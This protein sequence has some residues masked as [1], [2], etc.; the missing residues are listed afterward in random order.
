ME[1]VVSILS[2][3]SAFAPGMYGSVCM[4]AC[5]CAAKG[6]RALGG[7]FPGS[8]R[9]SKCIEKNNFHWCCS[10][11]DVLGLRNAAINGVQWIHWDTNHRA[12]YLSNRRLH[13][14]ANR[15]YA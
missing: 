2:S 13:I 12:V 11:H 10:R 14:Y 3:S 15:C 7:R 5:I 9:F 8:E 1:I 6:K 4:Y